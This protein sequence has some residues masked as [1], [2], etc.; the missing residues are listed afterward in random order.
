VAVTFT[1]TGNNAVTFTLENA[2]IWERSRPVQGPEVIRQT[3]TWRG[4]ATSSKTGLEIAFT[5]DNSAA[6]DN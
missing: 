4:F 2:K 1:G 5:N 3:V 6:T